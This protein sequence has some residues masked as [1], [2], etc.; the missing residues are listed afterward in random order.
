MTRG[1]LAGEVDRVVARADADAVRRHRESQADR[2]VSI[3]E[4]DPGMA[5][6]YGRLLGADA[7]ALDR[8]LNA[9]AETVCAADPRTRD[10]RR[11]DALGVLAAGSDR[12]GCRCGAADCAAGARATGRVVIHVVA[13]QATV[14]GR[15]AAPASMFGADGLIP[16]PLLAELAKS[17]TLRPLNVPAGSEPHYLPSAKLAAYVRA[18]DLTCRAPGCDRPAI[19]C[20]IDHTVPYADGGT[21]HPSNLKCVCRKHHLVKTFWGW[22]D[23]QLPDGTVIWTTPSRQVYVTTPGSALLFPSLCAPTGAAPAR[24]AEG[25]DRCGDRTA[26]MPTRTRT[27]AENRSQRV[28]AERGHNR[29]SR[30]AGP[31]VRSGY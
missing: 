14:E 22:R 4:C 16:A 23:E 13:E 3:W 5:E 17:A 31:G 25:A 11:A 26:M 21:T 12:L 20:D 24:A 2:E 18:R 30:L 27:R 10:E 19:E 9:L 29:L 7:M 8:R 28:A 15:G 6:V 1:R